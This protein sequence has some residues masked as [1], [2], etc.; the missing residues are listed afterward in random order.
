MTA[1][2]PALAALDTHT[3]MQCGK[4]L[5]ASKEW[6]VGD[7]CAR[8]LGPDGV[9]RLRV[10]AEQV[11][12]PFHIPADRPASAQA[13]RNNA[14]A[15]AALVGEVQLCHHDGERGRCPACRREADPARAAERILRDVRAQ[16]LDER[17]AERLGVLTARPIPE[18]AKR[19]RPRR[20]T[21][22]TPSGPVQME[23]L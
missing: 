7:C 22:S 18:P 21:R 2:R 17:R 3:C 19:P 4:A 11:T 14:N 6:F 20:T 5:H 13:R 10:Y 8:K 16:P 15:R 23:L 1:A 9:E 12:D